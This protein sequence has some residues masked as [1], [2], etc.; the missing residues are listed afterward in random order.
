[1]NEKQLTDKVKIMGPDVAIWSIAETSWVVN[2][3]NELATE[4]KAF[5]IHA[6][7]NNDDVHTTSFY[8]Y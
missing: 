3:R 8:S 4:V 7:P 2:T 5:D 1:M 6:Y